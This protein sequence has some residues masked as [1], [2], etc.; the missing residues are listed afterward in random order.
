MTGYSNSFGAGSEDV[1]LVKT[2]GQR[3]VTWSKT[4]GG[5]GND[6]GRCVRQTAEGGYI[7]AGNIETSGRQSDV[8][9]IKTNSSGD[10]VWT[11]TYGREL[12]DYGYSVQP[13]FGGGYIIAGATASFDSGANVYLIKTKPNGDTIWTRTFGGLDDDMGYSVQQS[14]DSGFVIAGY[15]RSSGAGAEDVYLI[16]TDANG[17]TVWTRTFGGQ[18]YDVGRCV[19]QTKDG[20]FIVA[21]QTRSFGSESARVYL[22]KTDAGGNVIWTRATGR[23]FDDAGYAVEQTADEGYV[24]AGST[25]RDSYDALLMKTDSKGDTVW[26]KAFGGAAVDFGSSIQKTIDGGYIVA[27]Y[28]ESFGAGNGD[29]LFLKTDAGGNLE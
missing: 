22:I 6:C 26:T 25:F 11:K 29:V 4:Y 18:L 17:N 8:Y 16:K 12:N 23:S 21:G 19:R 13:V 3:N 27:G 24:I 10:T 14:V 2:D 1:Y 5:P 9:L 20:G 28:T 7:I 15:T